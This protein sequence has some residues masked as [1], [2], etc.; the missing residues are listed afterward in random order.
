MKFIRTITI[1]KVVRKVLWASA[2]KN[3]SAGSGPGSGR[4]SGKTAPSPDPE[5]AGD[6]KRSLIYLLV[7]MPVICLPIARAQDPS[8]P[9]N[10][11]EKT[12]PCQDT[13]QDWYT[14]AQTY[15]GSPS[16]NV[17]QFV[18]GPFSVFAAA[19]AA[20]DTAKMG[21]QFGRRCCTDWAV[22]RNTRTGGFSVARTTAGPQPPDLIEFKGG[23][24]CEDAFNLA[25][26]PVGQIRDCRNVLLSTG[27]TVTKLPTGFVTASMP[28]SPPTR[29]GNA[30]NGTFRT[31]DGSVYH[32]NVSGNS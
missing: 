9:W 5:A 25:G 16:T 28:P 23:M 3:T 15:P 17:W 29:S 19:M 1:T 30:C 12:S 4:A 11:Y 13:R 10:V 24:C 8:R 32:L 21:A 20:A 7:A 26:F 6:A 22:F 2:G 31:S 18:Q 27:V 14:V